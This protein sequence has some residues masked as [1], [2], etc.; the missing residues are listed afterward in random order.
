MAKYNNSFIICDFETGGIPKVLKKR[1]TIE[2]AVTEIAMVAVDNETLEIIDQFSCLFKP[3]KK[4]LIYQQVAL[5]VSHITL[6]M[7]EKDGLEMSDAFDKIC[8]FVKKHTKGKSNKPQLCGHNFQ[9]FDLE[10]M[11]NLFELNG[12]D[13]ED[14][15][16]DRVWDTLYFARLQAIEAPNFKLAT[17][18]QDHQIDIVDAHRALTDTIA[19]AKLW[20]KF[21][22]SLRNKNQVS[23]QVEVKRFRHQFE[24]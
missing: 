20:I 15:F 17:V 24:F 12:K 2:V 23:N 5:D 8:Q 21:V 4:D 1:A 10:F 19:T 22:Q 3:Y 16:D 9:D 6:D 14:Y 18:L 13:A 11:V 7:L